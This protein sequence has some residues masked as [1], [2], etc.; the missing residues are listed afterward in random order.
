MDRLELVGEF[1]LIL[2]LLV[3]FWGCIQYVPRDFN[4][5]HNVLLWVPR[6]PPVSNTV[7]RKGAPSV[8]CNLVD[9]YRKESLGL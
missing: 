8:D 5:F 6:R 2:L 1:K 7:E 3:E 9:L 4:I